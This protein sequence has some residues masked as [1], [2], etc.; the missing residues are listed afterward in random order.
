MGNSL[1]SLPAD[2][3]SFLMD[4]AQCL[5]YEGVGLDYTKISDFAAEATSSDVSE[6]RE[7]MALIA[8]YDFDIGEKDVRMA[9]KDII[10]KVR[11]EEVC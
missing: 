1:S 6:I 10:Y 8:D 3:D 7:N 2:V 4:I 9:Y 5:D 11:G